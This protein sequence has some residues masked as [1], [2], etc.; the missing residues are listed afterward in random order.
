M[1]EARGLEVQERRID[2]THLMH[3]A[4]RRD[5]PGR[6]LPCATSPVPLLLLV[7]SV[8]A[9]LAV[10]NGLRPSARPLVMIPSFFAAWLTVELAPQ[11]SC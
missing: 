5:R 7:L 6:R 1:C 3:G 4:T 11:L 10:V 2:T 8:L 9:L